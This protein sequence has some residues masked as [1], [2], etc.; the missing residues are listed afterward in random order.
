MTTIVG[1]PVPATAETRALPSCQGS[2]FMRSAG[3]FSTVRYSSPEWA[4]MKT[5][6]VEANLAAVKASEGSFIVEEMIVV[7][8]LWAR[9]EMASKGEERY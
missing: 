6:A 5:R 1:V 2:R 3:W 7:F 8:S 4:F 9:V